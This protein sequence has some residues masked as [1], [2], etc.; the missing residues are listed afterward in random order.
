MIRIV[1]VSGYK[2]SGKTTLCRK[3]LHEL[4]S[5]GVCTG[6]IKRTSDEV[7]SDR[8]TDTGSVAEMGIGAVL[9]GRDGLRYEMPANEEISPQYIASRYFPD[10]E[11]L[12]IEGGKSLMLPKIW[13]STEG[14]DPPSY[15]GIFMIYDRHGNKEG[16]MVY[17]SGEEKQMACRLA[18]LVR[19]KAYRSSKIYFGDTPLP[20]KDFIADFVRGSIMGMLASLKGGKATDKTIRIYIDGN[21]EGRKG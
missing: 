15:P 5:L 21:T 1:A 17:R 4:G 9:W 7:V 16:R 6:Y 10:S 12:I 18:S 19:G 3:L 11:L 2:N 13:V 8:V 20:M 14:E